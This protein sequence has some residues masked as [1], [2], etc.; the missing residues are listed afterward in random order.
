MPAAFEVVWS[1]VGRAVLD[2]GGVK[3]GTVREVRLDA[4]TEE[5]GWALVN[6]ADIGDDLRLVPLVDAC[7]QGRALRLPLDRATVRAAPRAELDARLDWHAEV[8][9]H[10]HYG[11]V[12]AGPGPV[13]EPDEEPDER[14]EVEGVPDLQERRRRPVV[15][16]P[17][18]HWWLRGSALCLRG[19][20]RR[21]TGPL[22]P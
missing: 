21:S 7:E 19:S 14:L 9:L 13:E 2:R 15:V 8:A 1:W 10:R 20:G 18:V 6:L 11:L 17:P 4:R 3:V 16:E 22:R 5:P 12:P